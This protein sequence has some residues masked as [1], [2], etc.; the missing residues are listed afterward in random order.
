[1]SASTISCWLSPAN[2]SDHVIGSIVIDWVP[3]TPNPPHRSPTMRDNEPT[4][5]CSGTALPERASPSRNIRTRWGSGEES[6]HWTSRRWSSVIRMPVSN[7]RLW[8]SS[9][10]ASHSTSGPV[11]RSARKRRIRIGVISSS[12]RPSKSMVTM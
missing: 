11:T 2:R 7:R 9:V 8:R 10:L 12:W 4:A 1:M 5:E 3:P 6:H